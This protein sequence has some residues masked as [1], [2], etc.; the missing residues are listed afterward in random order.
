[1]GDREDARHRV[2]RALDEAEVDG[3]VEPA[4]AA[5][6]GVRLVSIESALVV[7]VAL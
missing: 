7:F 6:L 2:R 5:R 3:R 4:V 1:V